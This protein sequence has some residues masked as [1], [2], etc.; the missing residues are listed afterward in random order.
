[1][2]TKLK[3]VKNGSET[4]APAQIKTQK[5]RG[6][7]PTSPPIDRKAIVLQIVDGMGVAFCRFSLEPSVLDSVERSANSL[8]IG[9]AAWFQRAIS[10]GLESIATEKKNASE[11]DSRENGREP[12]YTLC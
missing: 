12:A 6:V 9:L 8:K 11:P 10:L 3:S 2:K 7:R 4:A 1:M 5:R